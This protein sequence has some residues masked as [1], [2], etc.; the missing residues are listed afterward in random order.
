M[1]AGIG[2]DHDPASRLFENSPERVLRR[3]LSGF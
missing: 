3:A 2:F 1:R